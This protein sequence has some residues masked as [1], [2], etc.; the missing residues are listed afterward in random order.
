VAADFAVAAV[1]G[2]A[3]AQIVTCAPGTAVMVRAVG[4]PHALMLVPAQV[5]V[6]VCSQNGQV[7]GVIPAF[8]TV[9]PAAVPGIVPTQTLGRSCAPAV[10]ASLPPPGGAWTA[11]PDLQP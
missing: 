2:P 7:I 10:V 3:E 8:Q 9:G 6:N 4:S 11:G 5:P 1:P